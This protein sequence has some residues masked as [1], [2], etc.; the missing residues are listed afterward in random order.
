MAGKLTDTYVAAQ[1]HAARS[2]FITPIWVPSLKQ[3]CN[4]RG[5]CLAVISNKWSF[6]FSATYTSTR[7]VTVRN[8][9][10]MF[11]FLLYSSGISPFRHS[12]FS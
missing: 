3:E 10:R 9:R 7:A 2:R 1:N 5:E 4:R 8:R 6:S 11:R 12:D